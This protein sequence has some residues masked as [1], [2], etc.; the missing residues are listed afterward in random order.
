VDGNDY[1]AVYAA[2]KWAA[3]RARAN[4][5]PTLIE[6]VSYRAGAHSTS[7]DPSKYRPKDEWA[8]WPLGDPI[9]RL[10]DHLIR[11]GAWS[12]ERQKQMQAEVDS[13]VLEAAKEAEGHGTLHDGPK[14]SAASMFED[15]YKDTPRHLREQRQQL[16]V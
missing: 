12:E 16:G 6:W 5:G 1:L 13:E 15:V 11:L 8:A 3:D 14:P 10:K 7:D 9:V 2:S 4:L